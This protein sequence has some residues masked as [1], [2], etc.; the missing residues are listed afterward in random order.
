MTLH[1]MPLHTYFLALS[2][3]GRCG[4]GKLSA[5]VRRR[6]VVTCAFP[7][8][9]HGRGLS[10][11]TPLNK[12]PR[13]S[14]ESDR[15]H[16]SK[17]EEDARLRRARRAGAKAMKR[18]V[19]IGHQCCGNSCDSER[20]LRRIRQ[21]SDVRCTKQRNGP[22]SRRRSDVQRCINLGLSSTGRKHRAGINPPVL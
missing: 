16:R 18:A 11:T 1:A 4:I 20:R 8:C 12:A 2:L 19:E 21:S 13:P 7:S 9:N 17:S 22:Y 15:S 6:H 3:N 10:A 14:E 5:E